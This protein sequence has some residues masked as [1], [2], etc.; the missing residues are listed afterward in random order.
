MWC[1]RVACCALVGALAACSAPDSEPDPGVA[2]TVVV[3][4]GSSAQGEL[5]AQIYAGALVRAGTAARVDPGARDLA[6]LDD[7]TTVLPARTGDLLGV[8][9]PES[10]ATS[11]DDVCTALAAALPPGLSMGDCGP[12]QLAPVYRTG[13]LDETARRTLDVVTGE[14]STADLDGLRGRVDAGRTSADVAAG[15]LDG[16]SG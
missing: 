14:L 12:A 10:T 13:A 15:W 11:Q 7:A 5:I 9:E 16:R 6:A 4:A 8:L 2:G 3:G 1:A